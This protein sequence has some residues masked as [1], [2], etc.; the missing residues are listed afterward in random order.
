MIDFKKFIDYDIFK[1]RGYDLKVKGRLNQGDF[2]TID[3]AVDDFLKSCFENLYNLIESYRGITWTK[4]LF[5]DMSQDLANES[6]QSQIYQEVIKWAVLEQAVFIYENG[7]IN[8][9]A[10]KDIEYVGYSP[11]VTRKLWSYGILR[12]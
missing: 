4:M 5:E 9:R 10:K 8:S 6:E 7:D 12:Y 1:E 2:A 11:K 3:E